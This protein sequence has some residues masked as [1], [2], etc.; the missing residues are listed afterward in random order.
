M[1]SSESGSTKNWPVVGASWKQSELTP[2]D[3]QRLLRLLEA[4]TTLETKTHARLVWSEDFE[5]HMRRAMESVAQQ[6][7]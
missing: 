6:K 4:I 1:K 7:A 5:A 2:E 3:R